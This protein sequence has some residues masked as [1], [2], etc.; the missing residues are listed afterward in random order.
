MH[1]KP[2]VVCDPDDAFAPLRAQ[3]EQFVDRGF[4]RAAVLDS[5]VWV[6]TAVEALDAVER[7]VA[8]HEEPPPP[9]SEEILEAEPGA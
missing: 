2:V 8:A 5:L 6:R 7:G 4:V 9:T 1:S 3:I